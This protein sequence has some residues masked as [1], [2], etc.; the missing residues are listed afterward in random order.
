MTNTNLDQTKIIAETE[1]LLLREMIPDD[2]EVLCG[3][4]C[5]QQ[6]ME[7]AYV[8]AFT[9]EEVAAWLQ[10]HLKRYE[11]LGFGL[12]AVILKQTGQMIGQCGLTMQSWN[13]QEILEIGYLF[14]RAH[15]HRGYATEAARACMDY[16]FSVLGASAVYSVIPAAH[17]AS[18]A[19]AVRNGMQIVD[20]CSKN[21]R[22]VDM[23]FLLFSCERSRNES[24]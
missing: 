1:R 16:A 15:W 21:F 20:R 6:A 23:D 11:T 2:L 18:R 4:M 22:N 10:R 3:I 17:Y 13:D 8:T 9:A 14:Q 12:W 5:D 7:A 19:V 24:R